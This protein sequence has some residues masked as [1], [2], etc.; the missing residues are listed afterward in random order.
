M[1]RSNDDRNASRKKRQEIRKENRKKS[2]EI[3]ERLMSE[4]RSAVNN[5]GLEISK[6]ADF[7]GID[8]ATVTRVMRGYHRSAR[9]TTFAG[10]LEATAK[11]IKIVDK[12]PEN[13]RFRSKRRFPPPP[14]EEK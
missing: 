5:C 11:E 9:F 10:I 4:L 7:S 12:K 6:V 8:P 1:S 2:H 14:V 13:D 3:A